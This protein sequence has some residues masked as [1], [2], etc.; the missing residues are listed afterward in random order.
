MFTDT[1]PFSSF[2]GKIELCS[3]SVNGRFAGC[4]VVIVDGEVVRSTCIPLYGQLM[5][6]EQSIIVG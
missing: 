2:S 4:T 6:E 5:C 1:Y 3:F